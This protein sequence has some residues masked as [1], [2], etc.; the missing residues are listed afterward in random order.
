MSLS[1]NSLLLLSLQQQRQH[2]QDRLKKRRLRRRRRRRVIVKNQIDQDQD[3]L[4]ADLQEEN[5]QLQICLGAVIE[6]LVERKILTL[7][8]KVGLLEML[9][10]DVD[11]DEESED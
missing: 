8:D 3:K 5:E 1:S 11:E 4:I 6:L 9:R 7:G 10:E 2:E